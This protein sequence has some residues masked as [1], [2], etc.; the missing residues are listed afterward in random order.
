MK[1]EM[2]LQLNMVSA[3]KTEMLYKL[4][5]NKIISSKLGWFTSLATL[6]LALTLAGCGSDKQEETPEI[7]FDKKGMLTNVADNIII[8]SYKK[9]DS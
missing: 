6:V 7:D 5:N 1:L 2:R 4:P 3:M 8:P 9:L